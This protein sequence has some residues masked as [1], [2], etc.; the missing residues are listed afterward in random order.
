MKKVTP[1]MRMKVNRD[2]FFLP[3]PNKGVYFR[4]NESTFRM[5]GASIAQWIEQ[6]LPMFTGEHSLSEMTDGLPGPHRDQVFGITEVLYK[7]GFIRDV[8]G[9]RPHQLEDHV[10]KKHASQI[11][12]LDRFGGSGAWRFQAYRQSKLLAVG[13][14]P[15]LISLVSALLDSGL[16]R[17]SILLTDG[18]STNRARLQE[19]I[20]H[21]RETEPEVSVAEI[22]LEPGEAPSWRK[23]IDPFDSVLY[24]CQEETD[25]LKKLHAICRHKKK[26]F[27]PGIILEEAGMAGPLVFPDSDGCWES[28]WRRVH[29]SELMKNSESPGFSPT[30]GALLANVIAFEW[31][32]GMT[33]VI[34]P[35]QSFYLLNLET[36]EGQWYPFS[37]HPLV[38]GEE[39][40]EWVDSFKER[41]GQKIEPGKLLRHFSKMTSTGAGI[42]HSWDE[43]EFKQLPLAVCR[44]Q[45]ADPAAQ[46][47]AELLPEIICSDLLHE[48]ARRQAGLSGVEAYAEKLLRILSPSRKLGIK[49]EEWIGIGAGESLEEGVCRG[50]QKCLEREFNQRKY[51]E[52]VSRL[53]LVGLEDERSRFY[54]EALTKLAGEPVI[55][56]GRELT[57]FPVVWV[58]TREYWYGCVGLNLTLALRNALKE[59]ILDYQIGE[60]RA[61]RVRRESRNCVKDEEMETLHLTIPASE[62]TDHGGLLEFACRILEQ[63]KKQ[64]SVFEMKGEPAFLEGLAGVYGVLLRKEGGAK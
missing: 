64:L 37:P 7:N 60:D 58:G 38:T 32:K 39:A 2:T 49:P 11:E 5:E 40:Y 14:G 43:G 17:F 56:L 47:P 19:L 10:L 33:G 3:E 63:N 1:S 46:G 26:A 50:L 8:S 29:R 55:A 9:D 62:V 52:P 13:S 59:A 4:N 21:A 54:L 25:E 34:D 51:G 48:E 31:F 22:I 15:F 61:G 27:M 44:V 30:A 24:V 35:G 36:M 53:K 28:A 12:F 57:G 45:A 18:I 23:I 6:L 42:F 41:I 20:R 16:P